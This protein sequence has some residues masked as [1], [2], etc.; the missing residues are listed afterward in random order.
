MCGQKI[1]VR[2]VNPKRKTV[3]AYVLMQTP[4]SP[5]HFWAGVCRLCEPFS[6]VFLDKGLGNSDPPRPPEIN[7]QRRRPQT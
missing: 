5:A 2:T 3:G 4:L 7:L 1:P 6:Q